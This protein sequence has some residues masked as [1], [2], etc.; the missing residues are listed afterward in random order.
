MRT[1]ILLG[2]SA[3]MVAFAM[4]G[5][6][7]AVSVDIVISQVYGGGGNSGATYKNDFIELYNRG[8]EA[9][10]V[11]G[12][13]VQY[14]LATGSS[15]QKTDLNGTIQPGQYYLIQEAAG[16]GGTLDLPAPDATGGIAIGTSAGKVALVYNST[17]LTGTC[18]TGLVDFVGYGGANCAETSPAS[19]LSNITAALRNSG[20]AQDTD[21]NASDFTA[22]PPTPRNSLSPDAA[23]YVYGTT[24]GNNSTS[25][26]PDSNITVTFSEPVNVTSPWF[27]ISCGNSGTHTAAVSG[28]P[29]TFTLNPD[30]NFAVGEN[31]TLTILASQV[32]DQDMTDPPDNMPF[33]FTMGFTTSQLPIPIHDIQGAG[34]ISPK[35]GQQVKT[36]GIVTALRTTGST[37]GFYIQDP[38]PDTDPATSEGIFVFT[39][40]SSNPASIVAVGDSVQVSGMV[41]EY[42]ASAG[43]LTV[44]EL[45]APYVIA[46]ISSGNPLPTPV[47]L[48]TGGR[49]PPAVVIENDATGNVEAS[50]EFDPA[51]DG[52]DFFESLEGM[53]VQVNDAVAVGPCSDFTTNREIPIVAD[54]GANAGVRTSRGGILAQASD[55][56]PERIILNDWIYSGPTLPAA[57]V[58]DMFPGPIIG[59]M[60]YS[61]NNFKLQVISLSDFV[62]GGLTREVAAAAGLN[63]VSIA[64]ISAENLAPTDPSSK[65]ESLADLAVNNL[66]SPDIISV[67]EVQDNNGATDDGTIVDASTTWS[68]LVSAIQDAQGPTYQYRQIDPLYGQDSGMPGGNI[69]VGFLFRTDRGLSFV[70][71]PGGTST[72]PNAVV[73]T[74][75]G[76]QLLYSPGRIDPANVA[77]TDSRKPLAGEF[78]FN[79]HQLFVISNHWNSKSGDDQL[80]GVKQPPVLYSEVQRNAQAAVVHDFANSILAA[81]SNANVVALGDLNDYQFSTPIAILKGGSTI[82]WNLIDTLPPTEQYTYVFEGNS[83]VLDHILFSGALMARPHTYDVVHVNSEFASK[84]GDHDPQVAIVTLNDPPTVNAGG[85]YSV[86]EGGS[87]T[88]IATGTDLEGGTLTYAWDLDN[89]GSFETPGQSVSFTGSGAPAT[90]TVAVQATDDGGLTAVASS[91]VKVVY[92]WTG[93]FEPVY[94]PPTFNPVKAGSSVTAK[95]SLGGKKGTGIFYSGYPISTRIACDSGSPLGDTVKATGSLSYDDSGTGRYL[96]VWKTNKKWAGTCRELTIKLND[97]TSHSANFKFK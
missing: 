74:G 29:I 71:R 77:F 90:R 11:T 45:T 52:I 7:W 3:L 91:S 66:Q 6:G 65:F 8:S 57:N 64:A 96:Y 69:R 10:N 89:N 94:N 26:P 59:V 19:T 84:V 44:T 61:Y 76:T 62:S 18:P 86:A 70:D 28:G 20:G 41:A 38:N 31:C 82:L 21:N 30:A 15:W 68:M 87:V 67:E 92:N 13:S 95:F 63:Q 36:Q 23:P 16:T 35:N 56:N 75:S 51:S 39:G 81:N 33:D 53:L 78:M 58:G 79:G 42:R 48:G 37:R 97:G 9:V 46:K 60:D 54:Y 12:W 5:N 72:A 80:F 47:V 55:F 1:R 73:G 17:A 93:F 24:P 25:V 40:G 2:I 83:E 22:G 50:G 32:S 43:S 85:P 27:G 4:S 34:H 49:I 14:A 88:L